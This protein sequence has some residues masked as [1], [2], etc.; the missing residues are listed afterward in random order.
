MISF[1]VIIGHTGKQ[2]GSLAV[3][4]ISEHEYDYC[5]KLGFAIAENLVD[6]DIEVC[7][8]Q[9]DDGYKNVY[10]A[11]NQYNPSCAVELHFNS[12]PGGA[13]TGTETLFTDKNF[14]NPR[15]AELLQEKICFVLDREGST[16]RGIKHIAEY[17]QDKQI[18]IDRGYDAI[19]YCSVPC[20]I[21]E[22]FFGNNTNDSALGFRRF[23]NL[24]TSISDGMKDFERWSF[25]NIIL[26]KYKDIENK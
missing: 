6:D 10:D 13:A 23:L 2:R 24:A 17:I 3:T 20:C 16:N 26:G 7:V 4:P 21:I 25:S 1:A 18:I 15:L 19:K 22:P 14:K 9:K 12:F 8:F 5:H 11:V